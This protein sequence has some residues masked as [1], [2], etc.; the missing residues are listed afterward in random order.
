MATR[1]GAYR[2]NQ[3]QTCGFLFPSPGTVPVHSLVGRTEGA[4]S[5][6]LGLLLW[7]LQETDPKMALDVQNIYWGKHL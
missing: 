2:W 3:G 1:T 6:T 5:L 4:V 7:V